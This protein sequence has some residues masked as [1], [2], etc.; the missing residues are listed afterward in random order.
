[1][2]RFV[3]VSSLKLGLELI[4]ESIRNWV[5]K[6]ESIMTPVSIL[7]KVKLDTKTENVF[8]VMVFLEGKTDRGVW[9]SSSCMYLVFVSCMGI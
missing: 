5:I 2:L 8:L 1:M 3:F 9:K 6:H 7:K 4:K